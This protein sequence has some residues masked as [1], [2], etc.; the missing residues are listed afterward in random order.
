MLD[1]LGRNQR[2]EGVR[3][4]G[5]IT[6]EFAGTPYADQAA[7]VLARLDV[8][9]GDFASAETRLAA[10]ASGFRRPGS[11]ARGA[12]APRARAAGRGAA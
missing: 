6:G 7:L 10:V 2:D 11:A 8:E 9:A 5:E 1:A 12:P 3:I 4:G